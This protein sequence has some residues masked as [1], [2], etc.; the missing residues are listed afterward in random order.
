MV[1]STKSKSSPTKSPQKPNLVSKSKSKTIKKHSQFPL[2]ITSSE[3]GHIFVVGSGDCGQLGLGPDVF[4]KSRPGKISYFDELEIV[5]I[6]AGGLHSIALSKTGK[7]LT[8]N[9]VI[10]LGMQRSKGLGKRW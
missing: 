4:E 10:F 1:K 8:I 5:D 2:A 7:V 3:I 9:I 6:F